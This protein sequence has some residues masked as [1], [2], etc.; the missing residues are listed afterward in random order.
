MAHDCP[1][2]QLASAALEREQCGIDLR[3]RFDKTAKRQL[4]RRAGT[5]DKFYDPAVHG[6]WPTG[7]IEQRYSL[8]HVAEGRADGSGRRFRRA[9]QAGDTIDAVMESP[10]SIEQADQF[11]LRSGVGWRADIL[12][13][14]GERVHAVGKR[15]DPA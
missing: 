12:F 6:D 15:R 3:Y 7:R 11:R 4:T 8:I 10:E 1:V 13:T 2:H 14:L 9:P 5:T